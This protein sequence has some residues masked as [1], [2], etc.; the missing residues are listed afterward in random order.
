MT[1]SKADKL[2]S[3][4]RASWV[5]GVVDDRTR[6]LLN[7]NDPMSK[8][9]RRFDARLKRQS[10]RIGEAIDMVAMSRQLTAPYELRRHMVWRYGYSLPTLMGFT[11][12]RGLR[13][14]FVEMGAGTG[15]WAWMLKQSGLDVVAYDE[16]PVGPASLNRWFAGPKPDDAPEAF[17]QWARVRW[18]LPKAWTEVERGTP[19][20]LAKHSDRV[21]LLGWPPMDGGMATECLTHWHGDVVV[22]IGETGGSCAEDSFW[23]ALDAKGFEERARIGLPNFQGIHDGMIIYTR[24]IKG[25]ESEG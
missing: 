20:D 6:P 7:S 22:F 19:K 12:L 16:H 5:S 25:A 13:R 17:E 14:P 3:M 10:P 15:Y 2:A 24:G 18:R 9:V 1:V 11:A 4:M 21:L 23:A 8:T